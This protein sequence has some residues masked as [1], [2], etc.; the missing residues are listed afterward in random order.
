MS[1]RKPAVIGVCIICECTRV[2]HTDPLL[3]CN[4]LDHNQ[5]PRTF[6]CKTICYSCLA[7]EMQSQ[8]TVIANVGSIEDRMLMRKTLLQSDVGF[9][10]CRALRLIA[11]TRYKPA[12]PNTNASVN[13]PY[14][15]TYKSKEANALTSE[16]D[17]IITCNGHR[18][19]VTQY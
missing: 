18:L 10:S 13:F 14:V 5:D 19:H 7:Q 4:P 2:F 6:I 9:A 17:D 8:G 3:I 12:I 1:T 16:F 15:T 11:K